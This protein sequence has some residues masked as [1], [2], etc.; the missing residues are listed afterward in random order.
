VIDMAPEHHRTRIVYRFGDPTRGAD[1]ALTRVGEA[2]G[3]IVLPTTDGDDVSVTRTVLALHAELGG[4]LNLPIVAEVDDSTIAER[5][6]HACGPMLHPIVTAHAVA[7]TAA[8]ALRQRGLGKVVN[9]LTDFQGSD[10]HVAHRPELVGMRF[11]EVVGRFANARPLGFAR[12]DGTVQINPPPD[13]TLDEADR[14]VVIADRLDEIEV[15][16]DPLALT[17]GDVATH[18]VTASVEEHILVVGWNPLGPHLLAG[19][20]A[21]TAPSSTVEIVFDPRAIDPADVAVPELDI[22]VRISPTPETST[23]SLDRP[24]TTIVVLGYASVDRA[25]ADSRTMLDM[26]MLRRRCAA[27][28][29][30]PRLVV[31]MLDDDHLGATDLTGPDD[32]LISAALGSQFIAQLIDQP[33]R[34]SVLLELYGGSH[35]SI[36]MVRCDLLGLVGHTS[37]HDVVAGA[38]GAGVVAIGW[39]CAADGTVVLNPHAD[40]TVTLAAGDEIVVVG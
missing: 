13:S 5:L 28:G 8:F 39:R 27:V 31:Q 12:R 11:D 18:L 14:L 38:Y 20:A 30:T 6:T 33:D 32:V 36:R 21:A 9:E 29:S 24:P 17:R 10:L 16:S 25:A 34:R 15:A 37:F 7:R 4:V 26:M 3:V 22:D 2:R 35:A 19:W 23:L 40:T 1:L